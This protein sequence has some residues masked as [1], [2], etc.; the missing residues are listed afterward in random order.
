[1][2]NIII[3]ITKTPSFLLTMIMIISKWRAPVR[4]TEWSLRASKQTAITSPTPQSNTQ[5][6]WRRWRCCQNSN[7]V[8]QG[9]PISII[10]EDAP[11]NQY[12]LIRVWKKSISVNSGVHQKSISVNWSTPIVN[13]CDQQDSTSTSRIIAYPSTSSSSQVKPLIF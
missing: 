11:K 8:N 12:S 1:M 9:A 6:W 7:S 13:I 5:W 10:N 4:V 2:I 3:E